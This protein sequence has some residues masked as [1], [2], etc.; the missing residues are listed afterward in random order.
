MGTCGLVR[1]HG[2]WR[3]IIFQFWDGQS[4]VY[5]WEIVTPYQLVQDFVQQQCDDYI[6]IFRNKWLVWQWLWVLNLLLFFAV[7]GSV[8]SCLSKQLWHISMYWVVGFGIPQTCTRWTIVMYWDIKTEF[9]HTCVWKIQVSWNVSVYMYI[10][11]LH[12]SWIGT[13]F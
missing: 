8:S 10:Q 1:S 13:C 2:W 4:I 9:Q 5:W 7:I 3:Q 6:D 12:L 11:I